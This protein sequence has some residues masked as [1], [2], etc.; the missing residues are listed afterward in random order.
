MTVWSSLPVRIL[1][2]LVFLPVAFLLLGLW[3]LLAALCWQL[4]SSVTV[5][6]LLDVIIAFVLAG[7]AIPVLFAWVG[8]FIAIPNLTCA[9]LAPRSRIACILFAVPFIFIYGGYVIMMLQRG[10]T[11]PALGSLGILIL[12]MIGAVIAYMDDTDS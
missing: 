7:A 10:A 1:R 5:D 12:G 6:S 9:F 2:W 3:Q 8:G 11:L 4:L